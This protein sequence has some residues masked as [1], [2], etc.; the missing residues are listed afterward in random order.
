ML[1]T[2]W[3]R[4]QDFPFFERK[5][6]ESIFLSLDNLFGIPKGCQ[7]WLDLKHWW[8]DEGNCLADGS[9]YGNGILE[10]ER[11][12]D[13][14]WVDKWSF[15]T[16]FFEYFPIDIERRIG[17]CRLSFGWKAQLGL[18]DRTEVERE[19]MLWNMTIQQR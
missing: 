7:D 9:C 2:L 8:M 3:E 6:E 1:Q 10:K 13:I 5:K 18:E 19:G 17:G 16:P 11:N 12:L 4:I 15:K 14:F